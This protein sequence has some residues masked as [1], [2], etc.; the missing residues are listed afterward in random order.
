MAAEVTKTRRFSHIFV[1]SLI[2]LALLSGCAYPMPPNT[3]LPGLTIVPSSS[4]GT[5]LSTISPSLTAS[6]PPILPQTSQP[7]FAQLTSATPTPSPVQ[8]S[9]VP[10][11]YVLD[12]VLD[13]AGHSLFVNET[14]KYMNLSSDSLASL[15]LIIE[16][17]LSPGGFNLQSLAWDS[18]ETVDT[19]ELANNL[20]QISLPLPLQPGDGLG[21]V[22]SYHLELPK[23][24]DIS[25]GY[26]P[27]AYGYSSRQVNLVDW[28]A[29]VPPYRTGQGWL[30]HPP[31][32][33]GEYQVY[34]VA[35]FNVNLTLAEP[36]SGLVIA[37]SAPA[38]QEGDH[39]TYR[40]EAA[41][42][43]ALS[44]SIEYLVQ[45]TTL[46][47]VTIYSYSFPFDKSAGQE[48]LSDTTDALQLYSQLILP[49]SR[50]TLS[51]VEADFLDGMEY[52]GLF[53]LSHGFYDLYDGTPKGYLTFIAAHET[54]H[55]WWY[56]LVGNDQA[57]EPWL[58][59]A[60]CTYMERIFYE[61]FY[62]DYPPNSGN[63]LV[64]WW[65]YYRV[66][67]Y[68]P[69]GWVDGAIYN[70]DNVRSYR[71]G[72]YLN[73]AKFLDGL[74]SLIGDAAFFAFLRDYAINDAHRI[75]TA[76]DFFASLRSHTS[77]NLDEL[78]SIYFQTSQ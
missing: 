17:N 31:W 15:L 38:L 59:E 8:D 1:A 28:Y 24:T 10:A 45:S 14:I 57:L 33:I 67:F 50:T 27:V 7:P 3:V 40:L 55:Q 43:F 23:L 12:A 9:L 53:F 69:T 58:D 46:D 64:D 62:S 41:R 22:I 34:D 73:G 68:D 4:I 20:L 29:Y 30:V 56:G 13:Y 74:R 54:A 61:N 19:Y 70:Y 11:Q 35:N 16:P 32:V 51:I 39:Y 5:P 65:W 21:L 48:V 78:L 36:V 72:V 47:G 25:I 66:D 52:D 2:C 63:S 26:R 71:D 75:A 37:A 18:G 49:Y 42:S 76:E 77:Q 6:L 44:A 60:L